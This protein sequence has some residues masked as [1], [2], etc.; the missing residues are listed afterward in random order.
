[1]LG[2]NSDSVWFEMDNVFLLI[3]LLSFVTRRNGSWTGNYSW[4]HDVLT[5][6]SQSFTVEIIYRSYY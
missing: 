4:R 1:M 6:D 2:L 5:K 3:V